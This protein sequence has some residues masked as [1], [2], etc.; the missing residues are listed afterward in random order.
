MRRSYFFASLFNGMHFGVPCRIVMSNHLIISFG[1]DFTIFDNHC[2]KNSP[3]FFNDRG[4]PTQFDCP[5]H[6]FRFEI[7]FVIMLWLIMLFVMNI[8][9]MLIWVFIL[10]L[11]F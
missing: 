1:N 11:I 2:S 6:K 10:M 4:T 5:F 8:F 9:M 7:F 3:A